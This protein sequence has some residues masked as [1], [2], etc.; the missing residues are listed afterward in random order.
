MPYR[1]NPKDKSQV[2]KLKRG[3]D[4]KHRWSLVPGGDHATVNEARKH[5]QALILNVE[6]KS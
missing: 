5:L 3:S 4:K 6:H 1:L 2:Q